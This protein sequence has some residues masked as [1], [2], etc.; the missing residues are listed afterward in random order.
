MK[1]FFSHAS[2]DKAVVEQI[3]LRVC[4]R[5]PDVKGWLDK[6]EIIGGDDLIEK[7]NQGIE[8]A[9][10]FLIFLSPNSIDKPWVQAELRKALMSEIQGVKPEFIVPVKIG[11]ISQFPPFLESK[12][13]V[14]IEGKT[15]EEWLQDI[16][17][18][19]TREKK[20]PDRP[21]DNI[22]ISANIAADNTNAVVLVFEAQ[23]WAEAIGFKVTVSEDIKSTMWSM[24]ALKGMQQV[25]ISKLEGT[26]EYGIRI[27]DKVIRPKAPF[28][29]GIEFEEGGDPRQKILGVG[30][31]DGSGGEQSMSFIHFK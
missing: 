18:A 8:D 5:F 9:D 13:Y 1:V 30:Q 22:V 15:Q 26:R 10:R 12:F 6:Y 31:W 24:S 21:A 2:E 19:I 28:I 7:I 25:S 27:Y 11:A 20:S 4:E 23:F 3:Y 29:M 17:A 14:D 16:H